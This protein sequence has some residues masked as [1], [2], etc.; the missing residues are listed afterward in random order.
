LGELNQT[1]N[2]LA[3]RGLQDKYLN[4]IKLELE[5]YLVDLLLSPDL[6]QNAYGPTL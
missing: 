5:R 1:A 3:R 2:Q 4:A 6:A